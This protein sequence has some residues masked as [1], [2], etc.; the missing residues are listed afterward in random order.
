[1][2]WNPSQHVPNCSLELF[3]NSIMQ[4]DD[5]PRQHQKG[6]APVSVYESLPLPQIDPTDTPSRYRRTPSTVRITCVHITHQTL[7]IAS[8]MQR[9]Y[10]Q[11]F[12]VRQLSE[13]VESNQTL[14]CGG[15][16]STAVTKSAS[17][18]VANR[19][20]PCHKLPKMD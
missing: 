9:S 17:V 19:C 1:M 11:L 6:D 16:K 4:V 8:I 5:R 13:Y 12:L 14:N 7:V 2:K 15:K 20:T 10:L 18:A 3:S